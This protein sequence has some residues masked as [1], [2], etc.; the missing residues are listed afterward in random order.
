[1]SRYIVT[2]LPPVVLGIVAV[3]N[4]SYLRPLFHTSAGVFLMVSAAGMVIIAS[5]VM[6]KIV[7]I[8][9]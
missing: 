2:A 9:V 6:R 8:E 5:L 4:P 7:D 1:M 3:L